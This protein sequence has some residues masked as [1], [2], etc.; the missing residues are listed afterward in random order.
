ML[1]GY[2]QCTSTL[3]VQKYSSAVP[4]EGASARGSG[5]GGGR[6]DLIVFIAPGLPGK[7][8]QNNPTFP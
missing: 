6:S 5:G 4:G 8:R 7:T 3:V 2:S 1:V